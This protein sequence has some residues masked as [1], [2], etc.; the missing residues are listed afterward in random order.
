MNLLHAFL[1]FGIDFFSGT[2]Q[3]VWCQPRLCCNHA[4]M[5]FFWV[6]A[7]AWCNT[8]FRPN[9]VAAQAIYTGWCCWCLPY[10]FFFPN[11]DNT[12]VTQRINVDVWRL[13]GRWSGDYLEFEYSHPL[14]N[15][16]K[17]LHIPNMLCASNE[18]PH[19]NRHSKLS[20][21]LGSGFYT[22]T[23]HSFN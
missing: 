5:V 1:W 3:M 4:F 8:L 17:A 22:N 18:G 9:G 11:Q 7:Q 12:I 21:C 14:S 19:I 16:S 6:L 13:T 15:Q 2:H 20:A 23:R 10:T